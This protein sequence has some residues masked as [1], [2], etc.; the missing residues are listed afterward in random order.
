M[1]Y[2]LLSLHLHSNAILFIS[3]L[4]I[5]STCHLLHMKKFGRLF[6]RIFG[7]KVNNRSVKFLRKHACLVHI[8][9]KHRVVLEMASVARGHRE[10]AARTRDRGSRRR[11]GRL[12]DDL[13]LVPRPGSARSPRAYSRCPPAR[14]PRGLRVFSEAHGGAG[15]SP[16]G[17]G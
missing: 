8:S 9:F 3:Y 14:V 5:C 7:E 17:T 1:K 13:A 6:Q 2:C 10:A 15:E 12:T 4:L 11:R 16:A